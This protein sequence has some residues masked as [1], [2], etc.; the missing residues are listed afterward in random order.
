M[1]QVLKEIFSV[2]KADDLRFNKSSVT[3]K[4]SK[5]GFEDFS[6]LL[7]PQL[8][9]SSVLK[10]VTVNAYALFEMLK[11]EAY[12]YTNYETPVEAGTAI[13]SGPFKPLV[14]AWDV[15]SG[16]KY[17]LTEEGTVSEINYKLW[18]EGLNKSN[19][20][21]VALAKVYT[22]KSYDPFGGPSQDTVIDGAD[23]TQVNTYRK[24][25][26]MRLVPFPNPGGE[27][28]EDLPE[29][30]QKFF[31]HLFIDPDSL[32]YVLDWIYYMLTSRMEVALVL[33][34]A[35]GVGKGIFGTLLKSLV[36]TSNYKKA[37][38]NML[39]TN[40]N[41]DFMN[42][43][44]M[45]FD[46]LKI[47]KKRVNHLKLYFNDDLSLE[48]KGVDG[49]V[50]MKNHNSFYIS[51]NGASDLY[52][53]SD[54]RRFSVIKVTDK[55]LLKTF[56]PGEINDLIGRLSSSESDVLLQTGRYILSRGTKLNYGKIN[57]YCT[58][59]FFELVENSLA[60]WQKFIIQKT[61]ANTPISSVR[62]FYDRRKTKYPFPESDT[63]VIDFLRNYRGIDGE[64]NF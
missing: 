29:E 12:K 54:D 41:S 64:S 56:T 45:E 18:E 24:S 16:E 43:R 7:R 5:M 22:V 52:I 40:F 62:K 47:T 50:K 38:V 60:G 3:Y 23:L 11:K 35:K 36:G 8:S 30:I 37:R 2:I 31:G 20:K 53:E 39:D 61:T 28:V 27:V 63:P 51:A 14:P 15:K 57:P 10:L 25:P 49:G 59:R 42:T 44:L 19:K 13:V 58:E 4:G 6:D 26:W 17:L 48:V 21:L 32:N 55:P 9:D 34:G 33:N 1:E 46:E